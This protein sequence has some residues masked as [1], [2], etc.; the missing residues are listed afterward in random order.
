M[1][2]TIIEKFEKHSEVGFA[3]VLL[4]PDDEGGLKGTFPLKPRARQ[5]VVFEHG[6]FCGRL[7]RSRVM[8]LK[9]EQ[10][11]TPSDFDGVLYTAV[12]QAG[13]WMTKLAL[14]LKTA[15]YNVDLNRLHGNFNS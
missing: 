5:N 2:L 10:V 7:G 12:D 13:A 1:A 4:T 15:G 3:V 9:K 8:A 14:E 11:E 6:Y